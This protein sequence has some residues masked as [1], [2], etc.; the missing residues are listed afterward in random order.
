MAKTAIFKRQKGK[1]TGKVV[2]HGT[3]R[4]QRKPHSPRCR[5]ND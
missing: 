3:F 1:N 5:N 4:C 2:S